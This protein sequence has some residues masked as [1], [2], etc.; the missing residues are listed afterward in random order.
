MEI[1][2]TPIFLFIY[3]YIMKNFIWFEAKATKR[4]Y[5]GRNITLTI[6]ENIKNK[7]VYIWET[8]YCTA[9]TRWADSEVYNFLIDNKYIQKKAFT[10]SKTSWSSDWYYR[11]ENP[12]CKIQIIN[13][14]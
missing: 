1:L 14:I 13:Q 8:K 12:Y 2:N 3:F 4:V 7:L 11:H 5:G 10:Y 6:Y 9:S